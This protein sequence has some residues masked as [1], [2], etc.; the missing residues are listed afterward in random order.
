MERKNVFCLLF[1]ALLSL[2]GTYAAYYTGTCGENLTWHLDSDEGIL[3]VSGEGEMIGSNYCLPPVNQYVKQ[4]QLPE[5]LTA[6]GNGALGNLQNLESVTI[7]EG[8][9]SIGERAFFFC[10]KLESIPLPAGLAYIGKGA[11]Q[12]CTHLKSITIPSATTTI[13]QGAFYGCSRMTSVTLPDDLQIIYANTFQDCKALTQIDL[14][15]SLTSIGE[16][17]FAGDVAL[18]VITCQ[19]LTP[20]AVT[21]STFSGVPDETLLDVPDESYYLYKNDAFWGRFRMKDAPYEEIPAKVT[22]DPGETTA[23]FAWPAD[24]QASSYQ[25]DI[26]KDGA[27][28][29]KLTLGPKGQLLAIAFSLPQRQNA[30]INEQM[31]NEQMVNDQMVNDQMVNNSVL[32]FMVTGL[33]EAS[34]YNYVLSALDADGK[35]IHVYTGDFATLGYDG[36]LKG[37][38]DEVIPTPPIVPGDPESPATDVPSLIQPAR[39]SVKLFRDGQLLLLPGNQTYDISGKRLE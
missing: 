17:A 34:R 9:T 3:V 7:P 30:Q 4:V 12:D 13:E 18:A 35:P 20:P 23:M 14:P 36:E 25:I 6:L 28:F 31:V 1:V 24:E 11:F 21:E 5:G 8:V 39:T 38:G 15:A 19:A 37:G 10:Q 26:Y 32:S 2:N 33:D 22:V 29:C 27:V 16:Q